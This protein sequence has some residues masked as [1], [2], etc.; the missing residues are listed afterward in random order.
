[1]IDFDLRTKGD[2]AKVAIARRLRAETTVPANWIAAR[3]SMGTTGYVHHLLYRS[4]LRLG[5]DL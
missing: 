2:E 4:R 1:M 3:L 5:C